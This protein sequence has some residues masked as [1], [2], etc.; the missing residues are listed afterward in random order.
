[1][2]RSS[3]TR[4]GGTGLGFSWARGN[5]IDGSG[6]PIDGSGSPIGGSGGTGRGVPSSS[7]GDC[8]CCD[9]GR[10]WGCDCARDQ[11]GA[12]NAIASVINTR[13][14][15]FITQRP[16]LSVNACPHRRNYDTF[17]VPV[18]TPSSI[19]PLLTS[20]RSSVM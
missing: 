1:M 3:R 8:D 18:E 10:V 17:S 2:P 5:P 11:P 15:R 19:Q 4:G 13:A 6:N 14:R 9:G 12:I 20:A 7:D 16:H